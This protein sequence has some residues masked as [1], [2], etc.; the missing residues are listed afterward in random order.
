MVDDQSAVR[1]EQI[2]PGW[3]I[4][5]VDFRARDHI[6]DRGCAR[7]CAVDK[8]ILA[9]PKGNRRTATPLIALDP[10][11]FSRQQVATLQVA[12]S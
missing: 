6:E 8:G 10:P 11:Q 4:D 7:R 2:A 1:V 3:H 12:I 9:I 5:R